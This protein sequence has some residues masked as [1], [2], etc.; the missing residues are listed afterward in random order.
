MLP[1]ARE[2]HTP[3]RRCPALLRHWLAHCSPRGPRALPTEAPPTQ[4][5]TCVNSPC[6]LEWVAVVMGAAILGEQNK[7]RAVDL[8]DFSRVGVERNRRT[9]HSHFEG[10]KRW[11]SGC[12]HPSTGCRGH[13]KPRGTRTTAPGSPPPCA[14]VSGLCTLLSNLRSPTRAPAFGLGGTQCV[15]EAAAG[16]RAGRH[17]PCGCRPAA[18]LTGDTHRHPPLKVCPLQG[19]RQTPTMVQVM[20]PGCIWGQLVS[21]RMRQRW[22]RRGAVQRGCRRPRP[23]PGP[24]M[25]P[26]PPLSL[27][28]GSFCFLLSGMF[29]E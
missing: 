13:H 21:A 28:Q 29:G 10:Q 6:V 24:P 7:V 26:A 23:W 5:V 8:V 27:A 20:T 17:H 2:L 16:G 22:R 18:P 15:S 9:C 4:P 1:R 14:P 3:R 12:F 11:F 19:S 25:L